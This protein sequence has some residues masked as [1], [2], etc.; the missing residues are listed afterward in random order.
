MLRTQA[1]DDA[2][3]RRRGP[4]GGETRNRTGDTTIFSRVLYQL[5]YLA[6]RRVRLATAHSVRRLRLALV[7]ALVI[8]RR[9]SHQLLG[10]LLA[11]RFDTGP[12]ATR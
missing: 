2:A 4:G 1:T 10:C 3:R 6:S 5:S 7:A 12:E 9:T 8:A 11:G